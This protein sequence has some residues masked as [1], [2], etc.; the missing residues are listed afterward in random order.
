M[1]G[2]N[3]VS[4]WSFVTS[5]P[6][7]DLSMFCKKTPRILFMC[8]DNAGLSQ[9]AEAFVNRLGGGKFIAQSA[10]I[11]PLMDVDPKAVQVMREIGY[12]LERHRTK[13]LDEVS[14]QEFDV[15]VAI[16]CGAPSPA[17]EAVRPETWSIPVLRDGAKKHWRQTR[18]LIE[19][20]VRLLLK[21]LS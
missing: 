12:H 20:E 11:F 21:S 18:N 16:S 10:G 6:S 1:H 19:Q 8:V 5:S 7:V 2:V 17:V 3:G 13:C 14:P 4:F 15:A 9:I